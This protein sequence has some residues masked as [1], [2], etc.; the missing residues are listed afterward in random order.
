[1]SR[2]EEE[3][4]FLTKNLPS[5]SISLKIIF[6]NNDGIHVTLDIPLSTTVSN[7]KDL[8]LAQW[9]S[10]MGVKPSKQEAIRLICMGKGYLTPETSKIEDFRLPKFNTHSTPVNCCLRPEG[11]GPAA[12][13][14]GLF[15]GKKEAASPS[16][17]S[18]ATNASPSSASSPAAGGAA[19]S[20]SSARTNSNDSSGSGAGGRTVVASRGCEC[21]VS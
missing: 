6:A 3:K 7:L 19:A 13:K 17:R 2:K 14:G 11:A 1:M 9:P 4:T 12:K 16:S 21:V 10:D 5:S 15:G 20:A 18:Q 8:L